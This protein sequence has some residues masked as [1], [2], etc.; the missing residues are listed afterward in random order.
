MESSGNGTL[1]LTA[2]A[3]AL[4]RAWL[5]YTA[6]AEAVVHLSHEGLVYTAKM[7]KVIEI[8]QS[9][10]GAGLS[11]DDEEGLTWL[12]ELAAHGFPMYGNP[13]LNRLARATH[14]EFL[15]AECVGYEGVLAQVFTDQ[16]G[17]RGRNESRV[18]L[19]RQIAHSPWIQAPP[20]LPPAHTDAK[21]N[22]DDYEPTITR[23]RQWRCRASRE[24][25]S[26]REPFPLKWDSETRAE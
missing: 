26:H 8:I 22:D 18:A 7:P 12:V 1:P 23:V 19:E 16:H 15:N 10:G 5:R 2:S 9:L 14:R 20:A 21:R 13:I 3:D 24:T 4:I 25:R 11:K 6:D 17:T